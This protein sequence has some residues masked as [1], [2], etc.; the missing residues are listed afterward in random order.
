MLPDI[1][2]FVSPLLF[3][4]KLARVTPGGIPKPAFPRAGCARE[5]CVCTL[6][7]SPGGRP[8]ASHTADS[9]WHD[10]DTVRP[11]LLSEVPA[12]NDVGRAIQ[13]A[14]SREGWLANGAACG[15]RKGLTAACPPRMAL[16]GLLQPGWQVSDER[17][18]F[19]CL[20]KLSAS[21]GKRPPRKEVAGCGLFCGASLC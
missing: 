4:P 5:C 9:L 8:Q 13:R 21:C 2:A 17:M 11:E 14:P 18:V 7:G 3:P 1:G 20:T 15:H 12:A 10:S 6:R 16:R 19:V